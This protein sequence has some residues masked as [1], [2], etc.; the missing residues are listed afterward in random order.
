MITKVEDIESGNLCDHCEAC[1][2]DCCGDVMFGNARPNSDNVVTCNDFQGEFN[3]E[4]MIQS[5]D[6]KVAG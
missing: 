1:F 2:A 5:E 6:E 3:P 4:I